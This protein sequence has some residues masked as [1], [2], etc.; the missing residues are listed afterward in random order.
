MASNAQITGVVVPSQ[1]AQGERVDVII[2]IKNIKSYPITVMV[3]G[4]LEYGI[5]PWPTLSFEV[6][7]TMTLDPS[8]IG[9][10][11]AYFTMP[12]KAVKVH[13]YSYY[14]GTDG[15]YH[16]D[17]DKSVSVALGQLPQAQFSDLELMS[18]EV[19]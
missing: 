13:G 2:R 10:F 1:A 8:T 5:S 3:G 12:D 7:R 6:E 16:F 15:T 11:A 14:Y 4:A 9:E 17:D 19:I 18:T